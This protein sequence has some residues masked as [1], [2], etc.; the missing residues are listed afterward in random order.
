MCKKKSESV[1]RIWVTEGSEES[2]IFI[3]F[4]KCCYFH[5]PLWANLSHSAPSSHKA[6]ENGVAHRYARKILWAYSESSF[7]E[8]SNDTN[9]SSL[10]L[11]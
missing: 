7:P 9:F 3:K 2:I 1:T 4:L 8:N 5:Y 10:G 6:L 11:L